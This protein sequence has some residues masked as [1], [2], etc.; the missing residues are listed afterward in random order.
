MDAA[1]RLVAK[2]RTASAQDLAPALLFGGAYFFFNRLA[3][4]A[5]RGAE[6]LRLIHGSKCALEAP[7]DERVH[8]RDALGL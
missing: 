3:K 2:F 5:Q 1:A 4:L 6:Y 8:L 7:L